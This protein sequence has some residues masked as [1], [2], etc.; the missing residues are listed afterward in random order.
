MQGYMKCA[1]GRKL[2][3][4]WRPAKSWKD[5]RPVVARVHTLIRGPG[6]S[7]TA[8]LVLDSPWIWFE[9]LL[10]LKY[11]ASWNLWVDASLS[12]L[13]VRARGL[14]TA[15]LIHPGVSG[16]C[17]ASVLCTEEILTGSLLNLIRHSRLLFWTH[18]DTLLSMNSCY[19]PK[20]QVIRIL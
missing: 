16:R 2:K 5:F 18:V 8:Y 20:I 6:L 15:Q 19:L 4:I 3:L 10:H 17:L 13:I 7:L 12:L 11:Y 14:G 9:I 1:K